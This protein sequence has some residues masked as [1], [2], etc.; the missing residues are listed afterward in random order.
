MQ[1]ALRPLAGIDSGVQTLRVYSRPGCHLCELLLDELLPL[2]RGR[3]RIEVLDIDLAAHLP[4]IYGT[5]IPVVE[6]D[7]RVLCEYRL[8]RRAVEDGLE[9]SAGNEGRGAKTPAPPASPSP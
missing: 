9:D 1:Q 8:D 3:A 2:V 4:E 7:G 5:R 6:L